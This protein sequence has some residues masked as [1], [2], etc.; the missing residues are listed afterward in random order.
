MSKYGTVCWHMSCNQP[1]GGGHEAGKMLG[2]TTLLSW[3][4][5]SAADCVVGTRERKKR[6]QEGDM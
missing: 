5:N 4:C 1:G 6:R 2:G 3:A